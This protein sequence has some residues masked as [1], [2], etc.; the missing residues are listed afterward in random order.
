MAGSTVRISEHAHELLKELAT[1]SGEPMQ[2]ILDKALE[3]YR[4]RKFLE[5]ASAEFAA[6][7]SDPKA[8]QEELEEREAWDS[9]LMDGLESDEAW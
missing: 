6:L 8:W 3:E 5:G 7:R 9:T 2:A 4:R 1:E